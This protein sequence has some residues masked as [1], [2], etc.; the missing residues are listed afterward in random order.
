[1]IDP[2]HSIIEVTAFKNLN[3]PV[4]GKFEHF[5]G[6]LVEKPGKSTA[7]LWV[8]ATSYNSGVAQRDHRV[9]QYLLGA[10]NAKN[11]L[12]R[13]DLRQ[14][15]EK[16]IVGKL[17]F[18]GKSH[19]LAADVTVKQDIKRLYVQSTN[20]VRVEAKIPKADFLK[21]MELCNHESMGKLVD[22]SFDLA[23]QPACK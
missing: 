20:P 16:S 5:S 3:L 12:A 18:R 22:L 17:H 9:I 1:M 2:E 11:A 6:Y 14:S 8:D 7:T 13:L 4:K 15:G 21:L 10:T 19:A 23:L